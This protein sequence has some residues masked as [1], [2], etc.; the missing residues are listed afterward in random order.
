MK[1]SKKKDAE[2][3]KEEKKKLA[4]KYLFNALSYFR[5]NFNTLV[6]FFKHLDTEHKS[7]TKIIDSIE[8]GYS[9]YKSLYSKSIV[10]EWGDYYIIDT[11]KLEKSRMEQECGLRR[12]ATIQNTSLMRILLETMKWCTEWDPFTRDRVKVNRSILTHKKHKN[13]RDII[14][15]AAVQVLLFGEQM[16]HKDVIEFRKFLVPYWRKS[17]ET[18]RMSLHLMGKSTYTENIRQAD[19]FIRILETSC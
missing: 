16:Q 12:Q 11:K 3:S 19:F 4:E 18:L 10:G 14:R 6:E 7:Q 8:G 17:L 13:N 9:R 15:L 5:F 1:S 2:L